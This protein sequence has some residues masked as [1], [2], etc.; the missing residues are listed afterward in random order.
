[1]RRR[2]TRF[3]KLGI[4]AGVAF[5]SVFF[6]AAIANTPDSNAAPITD[7][8]AGNIIDD[9]VFYN[10]DAMTVSQIQA[11]LNKYMPACDMWGTGAVGSGRS[12]NGKSVPA[13]TT[14]AEY[15]RMKR[16]AGDSRYHE[17]PYVCVQN[18]YENPET[19]RSLYESK[20]NIESGM[21]SAAQIIYNAAQQYGINPQVLLVLLKKESYVWGD[22]W[23]LKWE[24]NTVMGYGCPDN[25]PCDTQYYGFYNQVMKAA[26]QLNYYREH[27]YS[28]NY[29][30]YATNQILY[31][32]TASC[33]RKSVYL[34]NI[35]TTSL[36]IYTPYTPNDAALK[37][38]PG[39]ATCGSY[40]NRNFYMYF[41]E[42]F[43]DTH[44]IGATKATLQNGKYY[45]YDT[46][47]V[48]EATRNSDGTYYFKNTKTGLMLATSSEAVN[49]GMEV[50]E[51]TANSATKTQKWFVYALGKGQYNLASAA[52][53]SF[54]ISIKENKMVLDVYGG[55]QAKSMNIIPINE[56][57]IVDGDYYILSSIDKTYRVDVAGNINSNGTNIQLWSANNSG[58][59]LFTI[60]YDKNSG[61]YRIK[62]KGTN[63]SI[64][65]SG[66]VAKNHQNIQLYD[67]ND[68]CAQRWAISKTAN[69]YE[70]YSACD[71]SYAFDMNG[72]VGNGSNI[73]LWE[74]NHSSAQKWLI[75]SA[76][77]Q[78]AQAAPVQVLP[79]GNYAFTSKVRSNY[80]ID[81]P[82]VNAYA[83]A[84]LWMWD[85][86]GVDGQIFTITYNSQKDAYTIKTI[87]GN[88]N[89][90]LA[91]ANAKNGTNVQLWS[92]NTSC[93]QLWKI[94]K[95]SDNSYSLYSS[96]GSNFALDVAGGWSNNGTNLQ[97][98][99]RNN[100]NP[101]K[102]D[103]TKAENS[104]II[105]NGNY[106]I[107][108]KVRN[109]YAIDIPG[110][111]AYAGANLWM[112]DKNGVNGQTFTSIYNAQNNTYS[113][114]SSIS[115]LY[116][117]LAGAN[118]K[119]GTNVQLW[120]QNTSC[121]QSWK[122][123]K[124][125]DGSY[126]LYSTCNKNYALDVNGGRSNSGTNLQVW[127]R[128]NLNPQKWI[129]TKK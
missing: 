129:F 67:N 88:Y 106:V 95:N 2:A 105:P 90:D 71:L 118:A 77:T 39:E 37:A 85:K 52:N 48:F 124:N 41:K 44:S 4:L 35:A 86:N 5:A 21:I 17:P 28:Y 55:A 10:K 120:S 101:Q 104:A 107:T 62:L 60:S 108:S 72:T 75:E 89:L 98:W 14:R 40:G 63:R 53:P 12:I 100:L 54:V 13:N 25:A 59:Q 111:N 113:F 123:E 87:V 19:H 80:S 73:S 96:C 20:G 29:R 9:A 3:N 103:I 38:Y 92:P 27:I 70:F 126:S 69:G 82:G 84:N 94:E 74:A 64:D 58:A 97:V 23:P 46:T 65:V 11:H 127:Q 128:N 50:V 78:S 68:S 125:G 47:T 26:W 91:G 115:N 30:P 36:Y 43:G 76:S 81:I 15:A 83:G 32:P 110:E 34:E 112:W 99:Q 33:G 49:A 61:F 6:G 109:N 122:A 116:L 114:K 1:M 57:G 119:N 102:W 8:N 24:Y 22:N 121:A 117:D 18:Y 56:S 42:W 66:A 51:A 7:F 79:N 31:S 16:E 45:L 93:A